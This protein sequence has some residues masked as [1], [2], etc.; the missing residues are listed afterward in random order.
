MSK[1]HFKSQITFSD[2][3][4]NVDSEKGIV[5]NVQLAKF[6]LNK[7]HTYFNSK[8][9][10]DLVE[11]GNDQA[12]GVKCRFGHPNM[13]ATTLG[14]FLGRFTEF[15]REGDKVF[16]NLSL[17]QITKK[18]QVEG[19]G[20]SMWEYVTEMALSNP[21]MFG[22]SIVIS[23]N[24]F[25]EQVGK[26]VYESHIL[27]SLIAS[28]LVDD[29]AATDSLFSG[30][31]DLG[32]ISTQFLDENPEIFQ[33][34][35]KNPSILEDFFSRYVQY[36]TNYKTNI[37]MSFLDKMKKK[38]SKQSFDVDLTDATGNIITVVTEDETPKAG[39]PVN[40]SEGKPIADGDHVLADG[41][42]IVSEGGKI[43]E[44]KPK[45][46][47]DSGEGEPTMS[48]VMHSV[49]KINDSLKSLTSK[50]SA[51]EKGKGDLEQTI[52]FV[53]EKVKGLESKF[54]GLAKTVKGKTVEQFD[55]EQ[56]EVKRGSEGKKSLY[57]TVQEQKSNAKKQD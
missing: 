32:I 33:T 39:D 6:G 10:D 12:Q 5:K 35:A 45:E 4:I 49:N 14:S 23:S 44:I 34:I 46:E 1:K 52:E 20:I 15:R 56:D 27:D 18:T 48:E 26:K 25:Q 54:S 43:T 36:C 38:F 11:N 29:P 16:A 28:D 8:F 57:D 51:F 22:N 19:K 40:D 2:S 50:F 31:N 13:C 30:S 37:D 7:N 55:G 9:L 17:D 42:T 47:D 24:T 53:A 3:T 41:R 21:D